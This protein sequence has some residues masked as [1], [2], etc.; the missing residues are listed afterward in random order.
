MSH[1]NKKTCLY[2]HYSTDGV[3]LY[4][5]ISLSA[6]DRLKQHRDLSDW[7]LEIS[8]IQIESFENRNDALI[9]ERNAV[10]KENPKYNIYLKKHNPPKA[11]KEPND[12]FFRADKFSLTR[13]VVYKP[14][15]SLD[16]A[17]KALSMNSAFIKKLIIGNRIGHVILSDKER[18]D[19]KGNPIRVKKYAITGWQLIEFIE[20]LEAG[21]VMTI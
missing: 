3:L 20:A 7:F 11:P 1:A 12:Q 19:N 17:G 4:V 18:N 8:N 10:Q 13:S 16:E 21:A 9:A 2:R 5:G 15:Y 14:L 6:I